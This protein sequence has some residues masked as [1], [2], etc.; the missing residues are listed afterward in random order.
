[1][2]TDI[3]ESIDALL[4]QP[5]NRRK[6]TQIFLPIQQRVVFGSLD[7]GTTPMASWTQGRRCHQTGTIA[8]PTR[9]TQHGLAQPEIGT[10]ETDGTGE[11]G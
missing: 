10:D 2:W 8:Q 3:P 1:M 11:A 9:G 5:I 6:N 4:P 7:T